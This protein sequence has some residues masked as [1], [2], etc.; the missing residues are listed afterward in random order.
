MTDMLTTNSTVTSAVAPQGTSA[1]SGSS[2]S[3]PLERK[4]AMAAAFSELFESMC[5]LRDVELD[6]S[7]TQ[8]VNGWNLQVNAFNKQRDSASKTMKSQM[9]A[10]AGEVIG[11]IVSTGLSFGGAAASKGIG[12]TERNARRSVLDEA[13]NLS[14]EN[15]NS[16]MKANEKKLNPHRNLETLSQ[17]G[18]PLGQLVS[19]PF[20]IAG[21][22]IGSGAKKLDSV[23]EF[24]K[25]NSSNALKD[26]QKYENAGKQVSSFFATVEKNL[27]SFVERYSHAITA[28]GA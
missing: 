26:A 22:V 2:S 24:D 16:F 3:T 27:E 15:L 1:Q 5:Q 14:G 11:G 13:K 10:G 4:A 18:A 21:T 23:A 12:K 17:C 9:L 6:S 7:N 20:S 25:F 8:T 19:Q 28:G